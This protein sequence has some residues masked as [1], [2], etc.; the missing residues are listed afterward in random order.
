MTGSGF[1]ARVTGLVFLFFQ[2]G[3]PDSEPSLN[4]RSKT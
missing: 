4:L 2:A 3:I 1:M